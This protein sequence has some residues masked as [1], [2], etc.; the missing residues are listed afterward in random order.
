MILD[1]DNN[2][3]S[4]LRYVSLAFCDE[5]ESKSFLSNF[6]LELDWQFGLHQ[7]LLRII[8]QLLSIK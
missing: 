3:L 4:K 1:V 6:S 2:S 5:I 8:K 7:I